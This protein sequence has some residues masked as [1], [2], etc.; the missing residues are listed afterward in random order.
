MTYANPRPAITRT[1]FPELGIQQQGPRLWRFL[2]LTEDYGGR[3]AAVGDHYRTKAEA[4]ADLE[5]YA[6][7]TWRL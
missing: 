6:R 1:R 5:R 2:D 4:L 7:E 3:F